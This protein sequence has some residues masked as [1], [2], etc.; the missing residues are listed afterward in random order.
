V[1]KELIVRNIGMIGDWGEGKYFY[2]VVGPKREF[3]IS[4][5]V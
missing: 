4:R 3:E 5:W 1:I 2:F